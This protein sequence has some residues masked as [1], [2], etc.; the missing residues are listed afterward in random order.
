MDIRPALSKESIS[1]TIV[2][3]FLETPKF[4][5]VHYHICSAVAADQEHN[6]GVG[7]MIPLHHLL[8]NHQ[9]LYNAA[10]A[11]VTHQREEKKHNITR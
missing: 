8:P 3:Q 6:N 4:S 9:T 7:F 5:P 11:S 2:P 10:K 1:Y